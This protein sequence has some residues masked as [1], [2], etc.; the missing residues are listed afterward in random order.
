MESVVLDNIVGTNLVPT[1]MS[2]VTGKMYGS[3]RLDLLYGAATIGTVIST[4]TCTLHSEIRRQTGSRTRLALL[5]SSLITT[6]L[7]TSIISF[8]ILR[9]NLDP[10]TPF[11]LPKDAGKPYSIEYHLYADIFP[12]L[13][14]F[15]QVLLCLI[16]RFELMNRAKR[17][18]PAGESTILAQLISVTFLVWS[19]TVYSKLTKVGPFEVALPTDI[20]LNIGMTMFA[21]TFVPSY[22]FLSKRSSLVRYLLLF[23]G[24]ILS[25]YISSI[26]VRTT[27][28]NDPLTW[29]VAHIFERHQRI[30]LFS[31]WLSALAACVGFSTS[32]SRLVGRTNSFA[33]KIFHLAVCVVFITGFS[34]DVEFTIFASGGMIIVMLVLEMIRAWDLW[35]IGSHLEGICGSLRGKWDNKYLTLSHIYLLVGTMVPLW[36]LPQA[37]NPSKISLSSGVLA[38]GVGDAAAAIVGTLYGRTQISPESSKTIEGLIGNI[39]AMAIFKLIWIGYSGFSDELSFALAAMSTAAVEAASRDCD[40]LRLPLV[41]LLLLEILK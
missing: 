27:N 24:I 29:L 17:R 22:L 6:S 2:I 4:M 21:I 36:L 38:V 14:L 7:F 33:R 5:T 19:L 31:L 13:I 8:H 10:A 16:T 34:Q 1:L 39:L 18:F 32:W 41:M 35:P 11:K 9:R 20:L 15:S 25:Y 3:D 26:L 23:G 37:S 40:N 28:I 30:S 12:G